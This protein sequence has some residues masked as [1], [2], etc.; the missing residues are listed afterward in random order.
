MEMEERVENSSLTQNSK[1]YL[2]A[3]ILGGLLMAFFSIMPIISAFNLLCCMWLV[4]GGAV[5]Y[6][7]ASRKNDYIPRSTDGLIY[8]ALSGVFGWIFSTILTFISIGIKAKKFELARQKLLD[9]NTPEARR[10]IEFVDRVGFRTIIFFLS[11]AFIIFYLVFP[12]IGGALAQALSSKGKKD[13]VKKE[14]PQE[15]KESD[16]V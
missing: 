2:D 10:I 3:P 9:V 16:E 12:T 14:L 15:E 5:S 8:G 1:L 13:K 4:I 11:F 7:I 6:I